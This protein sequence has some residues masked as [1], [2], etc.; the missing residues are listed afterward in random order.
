[1]ILPLVLL[2]LFQ[3]DSAD[4]DYARG[5]ALAREQRW[6]EAAVAFRS[7]L[8][9]A[10]EDKRF[11][12]EL[13]GVAFRLDDLA[14][15]KRHLKRALRLDPRDSYAHDFLATIYFLEDNLDAAL[16]YWNRAGKPRIERIRTDPEPPLDPVLL[17]RAF[18]FSPASVLDLQELLVTR[19]RLEAL[20]VFARYRFELSPAEDDRF[21]LLFHAAP[22][23]GL[24]GGVLPSLVTLLRG[25]PYETV[26]P[27][28]YNL[29]GSATNLASLFR[30]DAQKRRAFVSVSGPLGGDPAWLYRIGL[31]ARNENWEPG[32][33]FARGAPLHFNLRRTE[34]AA[35][36]QSV[37]G[38]RWKWSSGVRVSYRA[39]RNIAEPREYLA[40][41]WLLTHQ[42]GVDRELLR[43]PDRRLT[44][45]ASGSIEY[46]RLFASSF[47]PFYRLET[48]VAAD[49]LPA[50]R[51]DDYKV[52]VRFRS[53]RTFGDIPFD[54][55]FVLGV[56]RDN[57]LWLRGHK[58]TQDGRKGSA[59]IA[60]DFLLLNGEIGK[61]LYQNGF[62]K[63]KLGPFVDLGRAYHR[64]ADFAPARWL[65][66][67][68]LQC[69]VQ[70]LSGVEL[71]FSY[72]KDL[73][74]GRNVFFFQ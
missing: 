30:W 22:R 43:I 14:A 59:P 31:D 28:I 44:V 49:W 3:A 5:M 4:L 17:D 46:G 73:R 34:A 51:G 65:V 12:L 15:A 19:A 61:I 37:A 9:K 32:R 39:F 69:K 47:D 38:S 35:E 56:E 10:P 54:E 57:K 36:I 55:F 53:G 63:I 18:A 45:R 74:S 2:L 72:G 60:R 13:A 40:A 66:D 16:R 50:A 20:D 42:T 6:Q 62:V 21:D 64:S 11:P 1:M 27:E 48:A 33:S 70:V 8:K 71:V 67:T 25:L 26:Y 52:S 7:G 68:G 23:T 41:G 58:G 24:G 29:R